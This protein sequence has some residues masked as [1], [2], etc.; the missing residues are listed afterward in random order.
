M[1]PYVLDLIHGDDIILWQ[2]ISHAVKHL[3]SEIDLG[4]DEKDSEI[5]LS[6]H[7]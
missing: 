6:C 1:K 2:R 3:P 5:I 4:R 7:I